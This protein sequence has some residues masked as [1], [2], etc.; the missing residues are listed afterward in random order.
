[1]PQLSREYDDTVNSW[2]IGAMATEGSLS[3]N[4][5]IT[6]AEYECILKILAGN[7]G[8]P[9]AEFRKQVEQ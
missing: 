3:Y 1:V 8:L 4:F 9:V 6:Q 7:R 5:D 2:Y